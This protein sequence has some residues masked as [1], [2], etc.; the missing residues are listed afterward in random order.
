MPNPTDRPLDPPRPRSRA[1]RSL[2]CA[3]FLS[4][5]G[6][7]EAALLVERASDAGAPPSTQGP[8]RAGMRLQYQLTGALDR[9]VDA[10]LFVVDLFDTSEADVAALHA[11]GRVVVAYVSVG[12]LES[13]RDDARLFPADAVGKPLIAYPNESWLDHRRDDV[14]ALLDARFDRARDKGFDGLLFSTLGAYRVDSGFAL[15]RADELAFLRYL[16]Q[17]AERRALAAGITDDFAL[18]PELPERF[19]FAIAVGCTARD[20]CATLATLAARGLPSYTLES[21]SE[22]ARA[23]DEVEQRGIVVTFKRPSYDVVRSECT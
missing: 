17:A 15:T 11:Q 6:A 23:C 13:F 22:R 18:L 16:A 3:L 2:A 9:S 20:G 7:S 8:V 1:L 10:E 4:G 21:E 14:R 12:S 5:C 19:D